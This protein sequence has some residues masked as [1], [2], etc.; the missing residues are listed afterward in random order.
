MDRYLNGELSAKQL[1]DW[2]ECLERRDDVAFDSGVADLL[3]DIQFRLANP[4]INGGISRV[5]VTDMRAE[6]D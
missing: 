5:I 3:D 2:A 1:Q 4:E 6:L